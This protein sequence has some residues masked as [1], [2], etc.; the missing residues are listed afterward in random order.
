MTRFILLGLLGIACGALGE[1]MA[2]QS[3]DYLPRRYILSDFGVILSLT[4]L[5]VP[6]LVTAT[7]LVFTFRG[8]RTFLKGFIFS[9]AYFVPMQYSA[10][11]ISLK[12]PKNPLTDTFAQQISVCLLG[13]FILS[14]IYYLFV[15]WENRRKGR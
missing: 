10:I 2:V 15:K 9:L 7:I 5:F 3:I 6:F 13:T 4:L 1:E 11:W 14:G 8:Y 12:D